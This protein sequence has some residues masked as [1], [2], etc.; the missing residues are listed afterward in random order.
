MDNLSKICSQM[1][2]G[3]DES[4]SKIHPSDTFT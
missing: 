4:G 2:S 1:R 3:D